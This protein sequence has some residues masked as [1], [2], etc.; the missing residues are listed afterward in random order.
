M[1][2]I[3]KKAENF[4]NCVSKNGWFLAE[5]GKLDNVIYTQNVKLMLKI[6]FSV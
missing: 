5:D 4:V 6:K 2:Y 3:G 1:A